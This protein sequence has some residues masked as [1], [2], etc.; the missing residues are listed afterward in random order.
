MLGLAGSR[1]QGLGVYTADG[2]ANRIKAAHD[3]R[4]YDE[5]S[6]V[7]AHGGVTARDLWASAC[8]IWRTRRPPPTIVGLGYAA[9]MHG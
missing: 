4:R 5:E 6:G 9:L 7:E 3:V 1:P 8:K 2:R